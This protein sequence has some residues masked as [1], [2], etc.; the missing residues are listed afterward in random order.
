MENYSRIAREFAQLNGNLIQFIRTVQFG[1]G[2]SA[3]PS[4]NLS[5]VAQ[6]HPPCEYN[7]Q[8]NHR[9]DGFNHQSAQITLEF[10]SAESA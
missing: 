10:V 8:P 5:S 7:S 6:A 1:K 9:K 3:N 4:K 2:T